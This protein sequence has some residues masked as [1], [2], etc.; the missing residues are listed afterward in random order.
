VIANQMVHQI[1]LELVGRVFPT[2]IIILEGQGINVIIG[3][4]W[5][6]MHQAIL[7]ISTRLI[8]LYCHIFVKV[9]LQLPPVARLQASIYIVVAKSM[10]EIPVVHE[11]PDVFPDDLPRMPLDRA[12]EV[13]IELHPGTAHVYK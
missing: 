2:S 8:H 11:Y 6:R 13:K 9:S 5:L 3:M 1:P 12:N 7:D 4:N 10:D